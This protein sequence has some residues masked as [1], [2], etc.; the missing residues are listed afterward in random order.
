MFY[1]IVLPK[2]Y[3]ANRSSYTFS[4]EGKGTI[5]YNDKV[6]LG[7]N[8]TVEINLQMEGDYVLVNTKENSIDLT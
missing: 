6:V 8:K 7:N 4:I 3:I 1:V 2:F 5:K